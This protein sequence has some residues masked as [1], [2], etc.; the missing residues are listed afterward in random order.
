MLK[1]FTK[2]EM[3][4]LYAD[5]LKETLQYFSDDE[6]ISEVLPLALSFSNM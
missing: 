3:D 4:D 6:L 2:K 5:V 1:L